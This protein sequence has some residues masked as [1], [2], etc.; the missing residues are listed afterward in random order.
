MKLVGT[1]EHSHDSRALSRGRRGASRRAGSR[2][3]LAAGNGLESL[4]SR[5]LMSAVRPDASFYAQDLG[6]GDDRSFPTTGSA[7]FSLGFNAP[8]NFF[9][10]LYSGVFVNNNGHISLG[11]RNSFYFDQNLDTLSAKVIAPFYANVDT[12]FAGSTVKYGQGVVDG[13][14]AFAVNWLNVDYAVSSPSH[15]NR[16][17]FQL[18]LIDRSDLGA[19]NF[20]MEF[21]Y[22]HVGWESA[23]PDGLGGS[24]ARIGWQ[25]NNGTIEGTYQMAG[26]NVAGAFL[27]SNLVS[28]LVH[29]HFMSDVDGR[30]VYRFRDGTWAD[31][32]TGSANTDPVVN[33]PEEVLIEETGYGTAY[34]N[35]TGTFDDP[36]ADLWSATVDY[37]DGFGEQVLQLND[38][39]SFNLQ[40]P[41]FDNLT[42]AVTVTVTDTN[43][44]VGR[45]RMLVTAL[46][47]TAPVVTGSG[48]SVVVENG[49]AV[50][51]LDMS[52][53]TDWNDAYTLE[54]LGSGTAD[55][56]DFYFHA[57]DNGSYVV[58]ARVS[59]QWGNETV[60]SFPITVTNAAPTADG[61]SGADS[62]D[63]GGT[64]TLSLGGATDASPADLA[65][66]LLYSFDFDGDGV[67]DVVDSPLNAAS[68]TYADSGTYHVVAR[69]SDKDGGHSDYS[70]TVHV[71]NVAPTAVL[72]APASGDEG[73][74]LSFSLGGVSDPS[75]ADA[76]AGFTYSFD[77][78]GDG[79]FEVTGSSP[80]V[81][82]VFDDNGNYTVKA[83]VTD[84]D[85]GSSTYS[86][87]VK[88]KNVPPRRG[89]FTDNNPKAEGTVVT[90]SFAGVEDPSSA[91]TAA[92]FTYSYVFDGDGVFEVTGTSPQATHAFNDNGV[93]IVTGRVTDKDG[94]YADYTTDV[95]VYNVAPTATLTGAGTVVEGSGVTLSLDN[96]SDASSADLAA[97]LTYSFD[98]NNDGVFDVVGSQPSVTHV[99]K[100]DGSYTVVARVTDKD[101]G[102]SDYTAVVNV[103]NA[104]PVVSALTNSASA[105]GAARAGST[106][107]LSTSYTDAG[108]LDKH[109][110]LVDW[111]DGTTSTLGGNDANGSGGAGGSHVYT[112]GG[113][114]TVTVRVS[115]DASPSGVAVATTQAI[116][117]GVGLRNGVL[118]VVGT[119]T[120]DRV[121]LSLDKKGTL[122]V[123]TDFVPDAVFSSSS[124]REIRAYSGAG[125]DTFDFDADLTQPVYVNG[126]RYTPSKGKPLTL[127]SMN[128]SLFSDRL[129]A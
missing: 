70:T 21:N 108:V 122:K 82:H 65:A 34:L 36:D 99:F 1:G 76:A 25:A 127:N 95:E 28:G 118:E 83:R 86:T 5:V 11:A 24:S 43:G 52:N 3:A 15:T 107:S 71:A 64:L 44:G 58:S 22:D 67:F 85:G 35:L 120:D 125:K 31:A 16:N 38:D 59:D 92:G 87:Q 42:H 93:F 12:R 97:G 20:D 106:V 100:N 111:G 109:T 10:S 128:A 116:V 13:H 23:T 32:P 48:P 124:V 101:G 89:S 69:V 66:G 103:T 75:A 57:D 9:G 30:Y 17:S 19:G 63:E 117:T 74:A 80:T 129:V 46:D 49:T 33:L 114:Y 27:D 50:L 96:A 8:I 88:V 62:L 94:G 29:N 4:E 102:Y 126:T 104:A 90:V 79:V 81:S 115:D 98:L 73:T 26:S 6:V 121:T 119:N 55:G 68:H 18:V 2:L 47:H 39:H 45:A 53:D 7:G 91:D 77:F 123:K 14:R 78:D 37:G 54:W 72:S 40:Y 51:S 56:G 41:F 112:Q 110:V 61:V 113:V 84:K 105:F 60:V